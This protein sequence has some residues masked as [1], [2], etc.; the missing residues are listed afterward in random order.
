MR[1]SA[2]DR[3]KRYASVGSRADVLVAPEDEIAP[4]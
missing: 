1:F 2:R 3:G 4:A